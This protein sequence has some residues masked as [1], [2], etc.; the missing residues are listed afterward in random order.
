MKQFSKIKNLADK[1]FIR[2]DRTEVLSED[3]L[4]AEK[5]IELIKKI[6]D[7]TAKKVAGGLLGSSK[8]GQQGKDVEKRIRKTPQYALGHDMNEHGDEMSEMSD[9]NSVLALVLKGAGEIEMKVATDLVTHEMQ[10]E[11]DILFK[12]QT[13]IE[14]DL[15]N[16]S[17]TKK[18]LNKLASDMD[19]ARAKLAQTNRH[20]MSAGVS[21]KIDN[22]KD[23]FEDTQQKV[24]QCRDN[25]SAEMYQLISRESEISQYILNY[26]Q[27]QRDYHRTA[28]K[29]F[30]DL[31]PNVESILATSFNKPVY[32]TSLEEHLQG[33]NRPIAYPIE[34]CVCGLYLNG[35]EE[36]GLFR[37]AGSASKVKKLK[38]AF[39]ARLLDLDSL[40][41]KFSDAHVIANALKCYLQIEFFQTYPRPVEEH[42]GGVPNGNDDGGFH[43]HN[44]NEGLLASAKRSQSSSSLEDHISPP[45]GS[46][47][48]VMPRKN[49]PAPVPPALVKPGSGTTNQNKPESLSPKQSFSS[50][51]SSTSETT[52]KKGPGTK[53]DGGHWIPPSPSQTRNHKHS[54]SSS[55]TSGVVTSTESPTTVVMKVTPPKPPQPQFYPA[56]DCE[57]KSSFGDGSSKQIYSSTL[58]HKSSF[59]SGSGAAE[60]AAQGGG[61]PGVTGS[62]ISSVQYSN[63]LPRRFHTDNSYK[64]QRAPRPPSIY[65]T[66][67]TVPSTHTITTSEPTSQPSTESKEQSTKSQILHPPVVTPQ[68]VHPSEGISSAAANVPVPETRYNNKKLNCTQ[69]GTSDG[70][71]QETAHVGSIGFEHL[72]MEVRVAEVT[73][74]RN[75]FSKCEDLSIIGLLPGQGESAKPVPAPRSS[76]LLQYKSSK[77]KE[78]VPTDKERPTL[79]AKPRDRTKK[80]QAILAGTNQD[81]IHAIQ[82]TGDASNSPPDATAPIH[83]Q[84]NIGL[85]V[86]VET[87]DSGNPDDLH[88]RNEAMKDKNML[89]PSPKAPN[90]PPRPHPPPPPKLKSEIS[91]CRCN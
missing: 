32:G 2:P 27:L 29:V 45:P 24:E 8:D 26:L 31:L 35:L 44:E 91:G 19:S 57:N 18:T 10:V 77:E 28:H 65:A 90:R 86:S 56:K 21:G 22:I 46:P 36:E 63:S 47:K 74:K 50:D 4:A 75:S 84:Q 51:S 69:P 79:M 37:I 25:L 89:P 17:K 42:S 58:R 64:N 7:N 23:D 33:I 3:L 68:A 39:D 20:S 73:E 88:S 87:E 72:E 34:L 1:A 62:N 15:H 67:P 43:Q 38:A 48:P 14:T 54:G 6:C 12:L 61:A 52:P 82:G 60:G 16:I 40:R 9:F 78:G 76:L 83:T 70:N 13:L 5:R 11:S 53:R 30:D 55:V 81:N 59:N 66:I 71:Q 41:Q 80:S 49:K 85:R